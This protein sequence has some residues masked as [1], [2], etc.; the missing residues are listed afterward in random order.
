MIMITNRLVNIRIRRV[1]KLQIWFLGFLQFIGHVS[2]E[3]CGFLSLMDG[4]FVHLST[5][6]LHPSAT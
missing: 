5:F 1:K 3:G 4:L 6:V 2:A